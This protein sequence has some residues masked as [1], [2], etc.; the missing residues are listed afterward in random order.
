MEITENNGRNAMNST[1]AAVGFVGG[2]G[3]NR[4]HVVTDD[5]NFRSPLCYIDCSSI[6]KFEESY[7]DVFLGEMIKSSYI[8]RRV[9]EGTSPSNAGSLIER[10]VR[11]R[12]PFSV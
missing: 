2:L 5:F 10:K 1:T 9:K 4:M 7:G 11:L 3:N 8:Y 12:F 6:N